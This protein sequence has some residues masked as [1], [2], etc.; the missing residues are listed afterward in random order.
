MRQMHDESAGADEVRTIWEIADI[1]PGLK[2]KKPMGDSRFV[3]FILACHFGGG[4]TT[5]EKSGTTYGIFHVEDGEFVTVG[6]G[7][8]EA[9]MIH[10]NNCGF[11]PLEV[12]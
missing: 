12:A 1:K 4:G 7:S 2:V 3:N 9:V 8:Q 6:N 10:L 11:L 5:F